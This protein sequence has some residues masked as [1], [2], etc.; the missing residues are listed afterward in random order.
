MSFEQLIYKPGDQLRYK[1]KKYKY[2][3]FELKVPETVDET[4]RF[5][6][7]HLHFSFHIIIAMEFT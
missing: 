6:A 3:T 7:G 4:E 5:L 2:D 1:A